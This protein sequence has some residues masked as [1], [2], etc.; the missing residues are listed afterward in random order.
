MALRITVEPTLEPISLAEAMAHLNA[1]DGEDM[2]KITALIMSARSL[3]EQETGRALLPQTWKKTLDEFPDA[4]R[5][6]NP[7]ITAVSSVRYLDVNAVWQTLDPAT[8]VADF[9]SEP[10]WIVPAANRAWPATLTQANVVEVIYTAGYPDAASVPAAIKQ[11][12]KVVMREL[13]DN[14]A[15]AYDGRNLVLMPHVD[16][17]LDRYRVT[18]WV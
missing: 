1:D 11:W 4:I 12:I 9:A 13:Y 2:S 5:L 3:A 8:Y 14:P 18:R 17:L 16:G 6:D 10:G 15:G 7:P